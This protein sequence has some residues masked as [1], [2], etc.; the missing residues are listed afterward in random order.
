MGALRRTGGEAGDGRLRGARRGGE[1][2]LAPG[3]ARG[4]RPAG[5]QMRDHRGEDER[6]P[7][8]PRPQPH[9]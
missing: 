5:G 9:R 1:L 6:D 3:A 7:P 2:A 8:E 4:V